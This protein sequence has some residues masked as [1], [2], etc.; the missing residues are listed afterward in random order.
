MLHL[1]DSPAAPPPS[2]PPDYT[3]H[4]LLLN[5]ARASKWQCFGFWVTSRVPMSV[6][7]ECVA[8]ESLHAA[9][10]SG[11]LLDLTAHPE[12]FVPEKPIALVHERDTG[13]KMYTGRASFFRDLGLSLED[14]GVED[15]SE[16][17]GEI[18]AYSTSD[19]SA[20]RRIEDALAAGRPALVLPPPEQ[21]HILLL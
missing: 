7:P 14:S 16:D 19:L 4:V 9:V 18:V 13:K 11:V 1:V 20:Q 8:R 15:S 5:R 3:G 21:G 17:N 2:A 10:E 12:L 6:V